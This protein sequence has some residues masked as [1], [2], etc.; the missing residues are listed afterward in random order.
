MRQRGV[1]LSPR[2]TQIAMIAMAGTAIGS[3]HP[4][5]RT[6]EN[7]S[8]SEDSSTANEQKL[9]A[10]MIWRFARDRPKGKKI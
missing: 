4:G 1:S 8:V 7:S 6:M 10:F 9:R 3:I 2:N 5:S